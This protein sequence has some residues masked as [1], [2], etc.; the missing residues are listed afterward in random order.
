MRQNTTNRRQALKQGSS[1][2]AALLL[3]PFFAKFGSAA[4]NQTSFTGFDGQSIVWGGVAYL[5][6]DKAALPNI[7]PVIKMKT[8]NGAHFLNQL[9]GKELFSEIEK[10]S[11]LCQNMN[12]ANVCWGKTGVD[13]EARFGMILGI[14]AELTIQDS[15]DEVASFTFLRLVSYNFIFSVTPTG[16]VQI[17]ASYPI[18]GRIDSVQ[19]GMDTTP[20]SDY[21][22]QMFSRE[23]TTGESIPQQYKRLFATRPFGDIK[24]GLNYR[25]SQVKLQKKVV[26]YFN[27]DGVNTKH[28]TEWLGSATTVALS[29]GLKVSVLPYQQE[30]D[31]NLAMAESF[32]E[33]QMLF[34]NIPNGD[35]EVEPTVLLVKVSLKDHPRD[36]SK[37]LQKLS[38][39]LLLKISTNLGNQKDVIFKQIMFAEQFQVIFKKKE[40]RQAD[41]TTVYKLTEDML[42]MTTVA[43]K[44]PSKRQELIKGFRQDGKSSSRNEEIKPYIRIKIRPE[45]AP[46]FE[47]ECNAVIEYT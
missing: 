1:V 45:T 6:S 42:N 14:A 13:G 40:W 4:V 8:P 7:M 32:D 19:Y 17:I 33:S 2:A 9:L 23:S 29:D 43:I 16:G 35:I 41:A 22:L 10:T 39:F 25:V 5:P 46:N 27:L 38:V 20:L 11:S 37:F 15:R 44:N 36:D 34:F 30:T 12:G 26:E 28:F 21:Y 3:S 24:T 47:A 31:L 18:G